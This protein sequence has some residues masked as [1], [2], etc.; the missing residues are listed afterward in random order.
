M[1]RFADFAGTPHILDGAKIRIDDVLNQE[2]VVTGYSVR[3]SRYSKN[4]SGKYLTLQVRLGDE[5]R[6]LF[7]GSDVLIQQ[8]ERHG[9]KIPFLATIRKVDRF[10]TLS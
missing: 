5:K 3:D 4:K 8:L 2:L 7:T 6:V 1:E 10:Y 9:D